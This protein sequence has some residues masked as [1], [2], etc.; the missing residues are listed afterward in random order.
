MWPDVDFEKGT[1]FVHQVVSLKNYVP[2]IKPTTKSVAGTRTIH[3]HPL[4]KSIFQELKATAKE[5]ET[6]FCN[7]SGGIWAPNCFY[8]LYK[9]Y[10]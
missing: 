10:I 1:I 6:V 2:Y 4:V 5:N 9:K 7:D 8:V 3:M